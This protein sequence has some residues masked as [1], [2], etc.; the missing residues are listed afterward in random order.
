MRFV[1]K[2]LTVPAKTLRKM[3]WVAF[4]GTEFDSYEECSDY[5]RNTKLKST[6]V[7][8]Q[9]IENIHEFCKGYLATLFF[10]QSQEDYNTMM[11]IKSMHHLSDTSDT[12]EQCGPGWYMHHWEDNG[13]IHGIDFINSLSKY[14]SNLEERWWQWKY[15]VA[16]KTGPAIGV[17]QIHNVCS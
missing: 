2:K 16:Q 15:D 10:I 13:S 9:K 4:D 6:G 1:E 8:E 12:F 5:E 11:E 3:V 14:I 7:F 17:G